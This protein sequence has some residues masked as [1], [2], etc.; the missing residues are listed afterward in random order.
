ME[1]IVFGTNEFDL[2]PVGI[3]HNDVTKRRGFKFT[4]DLPYQE[5]ED[6]LTDPESFAVIKYQ[7]E[8]GLV[9]ATYADCVSLKTLSKDIETGIYTAEFSTD[10]VARRMADLEAEI[11][12]LKAEKK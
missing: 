9:V 12:A 8:D 3:S 10:E 4:S 6:V 1:K 2:V 5:I 11:E 7:L